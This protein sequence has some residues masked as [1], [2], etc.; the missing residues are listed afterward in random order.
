MT[1]RIAIDDS[2]RKCRKYTVVADNSSI[3]Y[4]FDGR[5]FGA[6]LLDECYVE[7]GICDSMINIDKREYFS[8][9]VITQNEK[10]VLE[11]IKLISVYFP[12]L[13]KDYDRVFAIK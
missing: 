4:N 5:F 2:D 9:K 7:D 11:H 3:Q 10:S 13:I 8:Q 6:A 1:V 12:K